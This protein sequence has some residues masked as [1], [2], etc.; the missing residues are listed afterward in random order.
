RACRRETC[1][2]GS[3]TSQPASRPTSS[4][5]LASGTLR[6]LQAG[7]VKVSVYMTLQLFNAS[8]FFSEDVH[9]H[10]DPP[11]LQVVVELGHEPGG[12]EP[13]FHLAVGVEALM[14][15]GED[16]LH[17]DH[18]HLHPGDLRDGADLP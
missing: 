3:T 8:T 11:P 10:R 12:D 15:E 16:V 6:G 5:S 4:W 1:L 9:V 13:T 14:L 7:S 17:G 18:L 2:D